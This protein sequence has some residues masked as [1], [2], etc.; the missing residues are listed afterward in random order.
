M[1]MDGITN[2]LQKTRNM[3]TKAKNDQGKT[4]K[5]KFTFMAFGLTMVDNIRKKSKRKNMMS[6]NESV[7]TSASLCAF[8]RNPILIFLFFKSSSLQPTFNLEF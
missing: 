6:F 5:K 1:K 7:L 2:M 3:L 4:L 8:L